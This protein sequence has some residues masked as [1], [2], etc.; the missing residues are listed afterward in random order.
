MLS[1]SISYYHNPVSRVKI[2]RNNGK[3]HPLVIF[4]V[5]M[6]VNFSNVVMVFVLARVVSHRQ[7][8]GLMNPWRRLVIRAWRICI[9]NENQIRNL[10]MQNGMYGGVRGRKSGVGRKLL[11]FHSTWLVVWFILMFWLI[12]V[13]SIEDRVKL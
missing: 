9:P 12:V 13:Y 10:S 6:S 7:G 8:N 1:M 4:D 11:C 5:F 3:V 2:G